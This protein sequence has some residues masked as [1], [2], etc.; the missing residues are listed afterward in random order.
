M[1]A[2]REV[3]S[4]DGPVIYAGL[5]DHHPAH[6]CNNITSRGAQ[7]NERQSECRASTSVPETKTPDERDP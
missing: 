7:A 1:N 5:F 2:G 4:F 6:V 3:H